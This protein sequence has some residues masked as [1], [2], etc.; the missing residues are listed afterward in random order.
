MKTLFRLFSVI[1]LCLLA[2][3]DDNEIPVIEV[4]PEKGVNTCIMSFTGSFDGYDGTTRAAGEYEWAD[5]DKLYITFGGASGASGV[6]EYASADSLWLVT[7][8]GTLVQGETTECSVRFFENAVHSND[9]V[10]L[11]AHSVSYASTYAF[12]NYA[13]DMIR[14]KGFLAPTT[15][16][17]HFVADTL[18]TFALSGIRYNTMYT[19]SGDSLQT[20]DSPLSLTM[21][22]GDSTYVTDYIY[23]LY[24]DTA[25]RKLEL[26]NDSLCYSKIFPAAMLSPAVCGYI[27]LP[28]PDACNGWEVYANAGHGYVDLGLPSGLKW[29]TCNVGASA[30][31]EY[32]NHYA[33]GEVSYKDEY[34]EENS[35]TSGLGFGGISGHAAYDAARAVWTGEWRMPTSAEFEELRNHCT[36]EWITEN[37]VGGC[38]VTGSNGNSIF[39]PADSIG[40]SYWSAT[41]YDSCN[42][43]GLDFTGSDDLT[44]GGFLRSRGSV[45]RPV[46]GG[47]YFGL[48]NK[49]LEAAAVAAEYTVNVGSNIAWTATATESWLTVTKIDNAS[50]VVGVDSNLVLMPRSAVIAFSDSENGNALD[51]LFVTQVAAEP[52]FTLAATEMTA[53]AAAGRYP[54]EI[55]TN[56]EWA[57]EV[58]AEWITLLRTSVETMDEWTS[59]NKNH[60]STSQNEYTFDVE[61]GD[62][63]SFNWSVSSETNYDY[64]TITLDGTQIVRQSGTN[65]GNYTYVFTAAGTHT[66]QAVYSKD[67]SNSVGNDEGRIYNITLTNSVPASLMVCVDENSLSLPRTATITFTRSDSGEELGTVTVTQAGAES[68]EN[69]TPEHVDLGL[70]SGLKWATCNVGAT[71]PEEY[72]NYYA[73]G[74]VNT[75]EDYT[76]ST[77]LTYGMELGDISGNPQYDAATANWGGTWRMPTSEEFQELLDNCTWEWMTYNGKNGYKVTGSNGNYIFLPAAGC[78]DG[79]S[80]Y[81]VGSLGYYWSSTPYDTGRACYLDFGSGSHGT[82]WLSRYYGRSVRPVKS[83][84]PAVSA[85][86]S[87]DLGLPSG[88]KWAT[89]NVGATAP[90][91][92]G[93]YYAWGEIGTKNKYSESTSLTNGMELGDISGNPAYDAAAANWGGTWRMP[94]KAE[95]DKLI[96]NCTWT[97]TTRNGVNGYLVTGPNGNSIFLP[98]AGL[99]S[100][101]SLYSDG[102]QGLYLGSTPYDT[103][104]AC[105]LNFGSVYHGT[106]WYRRHYG[107]SVRPVS[108]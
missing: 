92:Y 87:V 16:R 77:S 68:V 12:Y 45:V 73:W 51:T 102:S 60:S 9:S 6:A 23:A 58:D 2:S 4:E 55:N 29:A 104:S 85:Y 14:M 44:L 1:S 22:A 59:T 106:G 80:L 84:Q 95:F 47:C 107:Q 54:L 67:G 46:I 65:S 66:L 3:C 49:N 78:R 30:P 34:T 62:T 20:S 31:E 36:W 82:L 5:G 93:N 96:A 83:S 42:A 26:S 38:K 70:P 8:S 72:G 39:L 27:R 56:L 41:P 101:T 53:T 74:E 11:D 19:L 57:A 64:L 79:T 40:G 63:L 94:T 91:E 76:E 13:D 100:G 25:S 108:E 7:Y 35:V 61:A 24:A 18:H 50:F 90:E 21:H 75:K 17:I 88:L 98:A 37:G 105:Y 32:G 71:A 52:Y 28:L 86:E 48:G 81:H 69:V 89:C 15:G 103:D 33:W 99:R 97:W 43:Y 10:M